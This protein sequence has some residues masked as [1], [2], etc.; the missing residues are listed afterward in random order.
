MS[1]DLADKAIESAQKE[2]HEVLELFVKEYY[3]LHGEYPSQSSINALGVALDH[4]FIHS[5]MFDAVIKKLDDINESLDNHARSISN[6]ISIVDP[7]AYEAIIGALEMTEDN[8]EEAIEILNFN[9]FGKSDV[10]EA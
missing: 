1:D 3:R 7:E 10:G 4:F 6:L 9:N 5:Q 2:S 8:V